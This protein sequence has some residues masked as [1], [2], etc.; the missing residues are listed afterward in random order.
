MHATSLDRGLGLAGSLCPRDE[1]HRNFAGK[2]DKDPG[3]TI[4]KLN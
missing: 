1:S 3:V 2:S 4:L